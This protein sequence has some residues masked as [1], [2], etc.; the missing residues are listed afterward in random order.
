[1]TK[2]YLHSHILPHDK[3]VPKCPEIGDAI[4]EEIN[5]KWQDMES[6]GSCQITR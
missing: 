5:E 4:N 1:M 3:I 2:T 6:K